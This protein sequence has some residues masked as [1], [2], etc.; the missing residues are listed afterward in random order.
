MQLVIQ[1]IIQI[2]LPQTVSLAQMT[3][4]PLVKVQM[5]SGEIPLQHQCQHYKNQEIAE[6]FT[7]K[8][9]RPQVDYQTPLQESQTITAMCLHTKSHF[10]LNLSQ[11]HPGV[12]HVVEVF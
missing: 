2:T 8:P 10:L 7:S 9:E 3:Q 4:E 6:V 1:I 5:D 12:V 11:V